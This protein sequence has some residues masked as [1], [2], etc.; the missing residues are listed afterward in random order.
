MSFSMVSFGEI[1]WDCLPDRRVLGGAPYNFAF[2]VHSLGQT[3]AFISRVGNDPLGE[4]ALREVIQTGLDPS[5]I[6]RDS[7][8]PTGTVDIELG[9]DR[10]PHYTINPDVAYDF[11][12]LNEEILEAV[13]AADCLCFGTLAQRGERSRK[14]LHEIW[15]AAGEA[16]RLYDINLRKDCYTRERIEE[17]LQVATIIKLNEDEAAFMKEMFPCRGN[18]LPEISRDLIERWNL[19]ECLITLGERG[20]F[21]STRAGDE[22][23]IPG[24]SITLNDPCGSGDACTAGYICER[25]QGHDLATSGTRGNALGAMVATHPGATHPVSFEECD[26]FIARDQQR[27]IEP[28]LTAWQ[29]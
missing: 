9:D 20:L 19:D 21:A 8:H 10:Q 12:E 2:R 4:E 14:T 28:S 3:S 25:L 24:F 16:V 7:L 1:L 5:L 6:Q 15:D 11:I 22:V 17:S 13:R 29:V 23:Y 27:V 18:T 26:A